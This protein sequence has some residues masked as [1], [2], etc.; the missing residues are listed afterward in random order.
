MWVWNMLEMSHS[1]PFPSLPSYTPATPRCS[2]KA[3][4]AAWVPASGK[5]AQEIYIR[6]A[7][8]EHSQ[9]TLSRDVSN[10]LSASP[11]QEYMR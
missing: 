9:I 1:I 7:G 10:G 2:I 5:G 3:I 11:L 4:G 6:S 8:P